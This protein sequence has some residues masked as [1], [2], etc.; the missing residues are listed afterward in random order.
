LK[1]DI[2]YYL[3][4]IGVFLFTICVLNLFHYLLNIKQYH[5]L[6]RLRGVDA[7]YTR[8]DEDILQQP[9]LKRTIGLLAK[10]LVDYAGRVTPKQRLE[11]IDAKLERAGRPKN[12]RATDFLVVQAILLITSFGLCIALG[13]KSRYLL[14]VIPLLIV[15]I[16]W[17]MLVRAGT[18]RQKE[19]RR[20][21]PDIMDLLVVSVEAGLAFD[22]ALLKVVERYRGP[23]GVELNRALREMQLGRP[24]KDALKNM[25]DRVDIPELT[26]LVN[27]IVQSEQL[28]VGLGRVL[29]IQSDLIRE[30]RQQWVEEQAMK[31]PIKMLFPIIFCIFPCIFIVILGPAAINIIKMFSKM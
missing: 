23:V 25:A 19:I 12:I 8:D 20:E 14:I 9:F 10:K 11:Q 24:R 16:V 2:P 7:N 4:L 5:V 17:F 15:Y 6:N 28:G 3:V 27:A 18:K 30:K 26:S 21:L 22:M 29:R 1:F 13:I 31:A